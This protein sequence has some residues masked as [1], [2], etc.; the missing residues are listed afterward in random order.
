MLLSSD[1]SNI[2]PHS[3]QQSVENYVDIMDNY[4]LN[5]L[6]WNRSCK[7]VDINSGCGKINICAL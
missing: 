6:M 2:V 3:F 4:P 5:P 7:S 1:F